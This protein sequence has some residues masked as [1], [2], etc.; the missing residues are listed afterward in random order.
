M[1]S[2]AETA[3]N[4]IAGGLLVP[5][6]AEEDHELRVLNQLAK[7]DMLPQECWDRF[8]ELRLRD[9]REK[10]RDHHSSGLG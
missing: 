7:E 9:R 4:L 3:R 6:T 8:V 2:Q 5:L 1:A 10:I